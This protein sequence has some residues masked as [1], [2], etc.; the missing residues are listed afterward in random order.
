MIIAN[1]EPFRRDVPG[2]EWPESRTMQQG[3]LCLRLYYPQQLD[4]T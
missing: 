4:L 1:Q 2:Q 3:L